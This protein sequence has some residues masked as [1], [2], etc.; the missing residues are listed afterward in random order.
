LAGFERLDL[1]RII[2]GKAAIEV[3][4]FRNEG[5]PFGISNGKSQI[6]NMKS[7]ICDLKFRA[8]ARI[9]G[10]TSINTV[11]SGFLVA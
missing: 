2:R 1:A 7:E 3:Q 10:H 5:V 4:P 6:P 9:Q 8:S 11:L